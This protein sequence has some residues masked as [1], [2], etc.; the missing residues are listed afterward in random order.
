MTGLASCYLVI[1]ERRMHAKGWG[2]HDV[3]DTDMQFIA[4]FRASR[5]ELARFRSPLIKQKTGRLVFPALIHRASRI[6]RRRSKR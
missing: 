3:G 6:P 4:V 5:Y 2:A 1:P